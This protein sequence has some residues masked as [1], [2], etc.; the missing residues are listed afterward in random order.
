MS[1][2]LN[3]V[4]INGRQSIDR[5]SEADA[6][7]RE[8]RLAV[9]KYDYIMLARRI[10]VSPSTI[11]AFRSGRTRWPRPN[12]LFSILEEIGYEIKIVRRGN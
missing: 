11:M 7:L 4:L 6:I 1:A 8:V 3:L 9:Y 5:S 12:T 10:G 2:T